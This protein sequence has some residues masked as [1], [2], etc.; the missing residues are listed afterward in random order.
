M[1]EILE[2]YLTF[3]FKENAF[4]NRFEIVYWVSTYSS[5]S[6]KKTNNYY[7]QS[8]SSKMYI[9]KKNELSDILTF[10]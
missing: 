3:F 7:V 8:T 4:E 10:K 2:N 1:N 5:P 9:R 6:S